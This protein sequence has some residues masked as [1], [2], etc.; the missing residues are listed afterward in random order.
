MKELAIKL[1]KRK[2]PDIEEEEI[3][4]IINDIQKYLVEISDFKTN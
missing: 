4:Q 1:V 3:M 2:P